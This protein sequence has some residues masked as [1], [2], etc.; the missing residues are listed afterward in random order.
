MGHPADAKLMIET[1]NKHYKGFTIVEARMSP[2]ADAFG[3]PWWRIII[4]KDGKRGYLEPSVDPEGNAPGWC[5]MEQD[6]GAAAE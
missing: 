2:P 1:I 4:E 6:D 5:F 3:E